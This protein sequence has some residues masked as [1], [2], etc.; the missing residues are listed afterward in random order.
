MGQKELRFFSRYSTHENEIIRKRVN[1]IVTVSQEISEK[2][3]LEDVWNL[4]MQACHLSLKKC[5]EEDTE[6]NTK[7]TLLMY[8]LIVTEIISLFP[9]KTIKNNQK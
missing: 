5:L 6:E 1:D 7:A 8:A 9:E 2:A 4:T 3:T